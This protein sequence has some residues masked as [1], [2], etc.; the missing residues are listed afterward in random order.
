MK[1]LLLFFKVVFVGG[2][3]LFCLFCNPRFP[4]WF[5]KTPPLPLETHS[6]GLPVTRELSLSGNASEGKAMLAR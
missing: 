4:T 3:I 5:T 2:A 6:G 1:Q